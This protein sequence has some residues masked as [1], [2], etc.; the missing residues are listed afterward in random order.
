MASQLEIQQRRK[1]IQD[2]EAQGVASPAEIAKRLG[3]PLRTVQADI[4]ALDLAYKGLEEAAHYR[5]HLKRVQVA[6]ADD[7]YAELK[8]EWQRS[9]TDKEKRR[10][11]QV[12]ATGKKG[13]GRTETQADQEGRLGDP[14]YMRLML[15]N[16][17]HVTKLLDLYPA[18]KHEHSGPGGECIPISIIEVVRGTDGH[19]ANGDDARRALEVQLPPGSSQ[20]MG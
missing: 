7:R 20:G 19:I 9:K 12:E 6:K 4:A 3:V 2:L 1:R 14:A 17:K 13:G 5:L 10:A 8:A 16:D 11:K 18:R 15:D